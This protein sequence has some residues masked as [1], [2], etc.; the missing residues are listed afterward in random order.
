MNEYLDAGVEA[1]FEVYSLPLIKD[2]EL[3]L[4]LKGCV[5]VDLLGV[6]EFVLLGEESAVLQHHG[7]G[8]VMLVG[9]GEDLEVQRG[10]VGC[11]TREVRM[12]SEKQYCYCFSIGVEYLMQRSRGRVRRRRLS[13]NIGIHT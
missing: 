8:E 6:L 9:G 13:L 10:G 4:G 5:A 3:V 11:V 1:K 2:A 7:N 12:I